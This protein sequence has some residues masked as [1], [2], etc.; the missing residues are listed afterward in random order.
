[1]IWRRCR[2]L[3]PLR[4]WPTVSFSTS[5]PCCCMLFGGH[6]ATIYMMHPLPGPLD[7]GVN[8]VIPH[9]LEIKQRQ[10][11]LAGTGLASGAVKALERCV[12]HARTKGLTGQPVPMLW[13]N[14]QMFSAG[15]GWRQSVMYAMQY[16]MQRMQVRCWALLV[17]VLYTPNLHSMDAFTTISC[18]INN[19]RAAA[20]RHST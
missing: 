16:E 9:M 15:P 4:T 17:S 10:T 19:T 11:M 8:P 7:Q 6:Q 13:F 5:P 3:M 2:L 12:A 1:M 20:C 18:T 14:G